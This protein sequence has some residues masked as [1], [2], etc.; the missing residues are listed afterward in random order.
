[1]PS[2]EGVLA[3]VTVLA[4][5]GVLLDGVIGDEKLRVWRGRMRGF[6]VKMNTSG[7]RGLSRDVNQ[8]YLGL[9]DAIYGARFFSTRRVVASIISTIASL[10]ALTLMFGYNNTIWPD[11]LK[12][13]DPD[14]GVSDYSASILVLLPVA[15]NFVPDFFSLHETRFVLRWAAGRGPIV[16]LILI[17]VDF[18]LTTA[19]FAI[20]VAAWLTLMKGNPFWNDWLLN[21]GFWLDSKHGLLLF[22]LTTLVTSV[23]WILFSIT[24]F[25]A[26]ALHRPM[27]PLA[28]FLYR[29]IGES[30]RP[31]AATTSMLIALIL[32]G[33]AILRLVAS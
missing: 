11:I 32:T 18:V 1:M 3:S 16:I 4:V 6:V 10:V 9:F 13:F 5:C 21:V 31:V 27:R 26:W 14:A 8:L 23:F 2:I 22:Y 25:G 29:A 12:I 17:V 19:I 7:A 24:F 30:S 33:Y 20:G 15:C 28:N